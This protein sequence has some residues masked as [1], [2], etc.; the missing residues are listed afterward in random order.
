MRLSKIL[1]SSSLG[2]IIMASASNTK[3]VSALAASSASSASLSSSAS[4]YT[5][6]QSI[7]E[8]APHYDAFILDQYGVLHNGETALEGAVECVEELYKLNKKMIILSNTSGPAVSALAKLPKYGF[9]PKHFLG[10]VTSGEECS[11]Y[12]LEHYGSSSETKKVLWFTWDGVRTHVPPPTDFLNKCGNIEVADSVEEADFVLAHGSHVWQKRNNEQLALENFL[13]TGSL[14][15]IDPI[16][17]QCLTNKLPMVCAN[18]DFVVRM[19]DKSMAYMPG[20]IAKRYADIGGQCQSFGKPH[21]E[22]FLACL[23]QLNAASNNSEMSKSMMRTVHVGDSLHHDIAGANAANVDSI[24]ITSGIHCNE[25]KTEFGVLPGEKI[26]ED[27]I[28]T[29]QHVPTHVLS[30]F[31]Y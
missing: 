9:D 11:R 31:R 25:L 14:E 18:P 16:L 8:L 23:D 15:T 29:E 17:E 21:P 1:T 7:S 2:S 24:L 27:L 12:I 20:N 30:V 28:Q 22:H 5:I 13:E 6:K 10:A 26:L 4:A 3:G 19:P